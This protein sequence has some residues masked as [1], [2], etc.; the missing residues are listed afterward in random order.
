MR[1][2]RKCYVYT[3]F[4]RNYQYST[5]VYAETVKQARLRGFHEAQKVMGS[6]AQISHDH[7]E[8]HK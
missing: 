3:A 7:V 2:Q 8:E 5:M 4:S 1:P 6:H